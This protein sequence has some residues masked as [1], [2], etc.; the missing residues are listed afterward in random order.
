VSVQSDRCC[1]AVVF[2]LT[3][4]MADRLAAQ[5]TIGPRQDYV[6]VAAQLDVLIRRELFTKEIPAISIALVDGDE[7]VWARGFGFANP[8]DSVPATAQTIFRVGSVSK[9]FTDIGV[10]QRVERGDLALDTPVTKYLPE[11]TPRN[12]YPTPITLRE[13]MS[14]RAGLVREP[15]VGH[16]FDATSPSLAATVA[17]L[18]GTELVYEPKTRTKY[19]NAAIATVGYLLERTADE[20]F[21]RYLARAV[22][23][24]MG[25]S[26]SGFEPRPE[27]TRDLA[28][29]YMWTYDGRTFRA[30]TFEL[31]MAPAGSMYSTVTDL[32]HFMS[33]LFR[34]GHALGG[35]VLS[36][37]SLDSMW[38]P[39]FAARDARSGFGIGFAIG[40]LEGHR[41][42]GHGGAIYGFATEL[43]ALPDD[44]LGVAV[45]ATKDGA[46]GTTAL[47]AA[48]ALEMM[49]RQRAGRALD[50]VPAPVALA[51]GLARQL[52]GRWSHG[53][54]AIDLIERNERLFL[55]PVRGGVR[56]EL[57]A[58]GDT[59]VVDDAL[60]GLGLRLTR[61][62]D[63]LIYDGDTL[64]RV[65]LSKPRPAPQQWRG[66]I[67]EYGW[68]FNTLYILEKDEKLHAL[69]EWF[70]LYPLEQLSDS[71]FAFPNY[72]LY[73][74]ERL[75]FS[76]GAG[77]RATQVTA[78]SV[79]FPRRQ[80][81]P[82]QG[83]TFRIAARRPIAE[84]RR[85]A[86]AASPPVE[87]GSFR[88][89]ELVELTS[90][91]PTIKLDIRYATTN[92][93][94][95]AP[96]YSEA[97]AFL[98][99]PAAEALVRAHR[100]L[101][102]MGYG[103]LIHDAYRPWYVTKMFWEAT[104][105][106]GRIFVA[107]PSQGSRHNRGAAVDLTMFDLATG[108]PVEMVGVYD[109]Q[110]PRSFPD[111]Q[112]GTSLQRWHRE[113]LRDAMEAE[114]FA[115]Y[116]SEWWHFDYRDWRSYR[117]QNVT[118]DR[119]QPAAAGRRIPPPASAR[120]SRSSVNPR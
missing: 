81:G 4:L 25:L 59:L 31:G 34:R 32:A 119:I 89:G 54:R 28:R 61:I 49:L 38:S 50:P 42:V 55:M 67:G 17:S 44:R 62:G 12:P 11:F 21:A 96:L 112:G 72:G 104:P 75:V 13:L 113:L 37:A 111:Y 2:A 107:D 30:P 101:R 65:V 91:D 18:R 45:V 36:P 98:Q 8:D 56:S 82:E 57:L 92:N 115:V 35:Q 63:R 10:M 74:G 80:V 43:A 86:L 116:E 23:A 117:L 1:R 71:V 114:G 78:A 48:R 76:R 97:R 109:E 26:R 6:N 5:A 103:L 15:P 110:S 16:Y 47:V 105:D 79:V 19:S 88:E 52:E 39:Q 118:F 120:R 85:E 84:L 87:R 40:V 83:E 3:G 9:L 29:A 60:N 69:I 51:S 95:S 108:Q 100:K 33:V 68:D 27:L 20:P 77:G 99:R 58:L 73:D 66:L 90:L 7:V 24:P 94:L 70:F 14:H 106:S 64:E 22:L 93:F 102:A 41:R 53:D 46:N